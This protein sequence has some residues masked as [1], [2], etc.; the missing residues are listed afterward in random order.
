MPGHQEEIINDIPSRIATLS[1]LF[2]SRA[3]TSAK[4]YA[5][6]QYHSDDG[7]WHSYRWQD[8]AKKVT[9]WRDALHAEGLEHGARIAIMLP[10]GVPWVVCDQA[11]L[12]LGAISVPIFSHDSAG[13]TA[14]ILQDSG[15]EILVTDTARFDTVLATPYLAKLKRVI[16]VG[17]LQSDLPNVV[18][19]KPWLERTVPPAPPHPVRPDDIASLVYTS[20]TTGN[21]KGVVLSHHNILSN[22]R[23]ILHSFP[24]DRENIFLSFLPLSHIFERT[25]GY[26]MSMY[27]GAEVVFARSVN[28]LKQDMAKHRP[29]VLLAVPRVYSGIYTKLSESIEQAPR[30]I[31][32]LFNTVSH[33]E[34]TTSL[35]YQFAR[36]IL[37]L[38]IGKKFQSVFGGKMRYAI[39]GGA[40]LPPNIARTFNALGV[41]LYQGYGLTE[42]SPVI[43]VNRQADNVPSSIGTPIEGAEVRIG[44]NAELLTRSDY[45]M[46]EYWN[47]PDATA[48]AI[49]S[50]GWFHTGDQAR[51]DDA[52]HLYIIGRIKDIIVM[53]NGEKVPPSDM[54]HAIT[55]DNMFDQAMVYGNNR[56]YLIALLVINPEHFARDLEPREFNDPEVALSDK[57]FQKEL[58]EKVR[59][60]LSTF[61]AYAKIRRI[62]V[63]RE[64]WTVDNGLLTPTLKVKRQRVET[65]FAEAIEAV[66]RSL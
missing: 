37:R 49:D 60:R 58:L 36:L 65:H 38:M 61:P 27:A 30:F 62:I 10:N 17:K 23:A 25:A 12:S 46:Q 15:A 48:K 13:N 4:H 50:D 42:T 66:Y 59:E 8:I 31:Q 21:P 22:A 19:L 34:D 14:Y 51:M 44:D 5:Y 52:G 6:H 29:S 28:Q 11:A 33:S 2:A 7:Q 9:Q 54:E 41:P 20:G 39:S 63:A 55:E 16:I 53:S 57:R 32:K 1:E 64:A 18:C 3:A 35:S 43:S 40:A 24:L 56:H 26:Y 45:V 47:L